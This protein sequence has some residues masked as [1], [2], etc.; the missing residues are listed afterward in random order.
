MIILERP[1]DAWMFRVGRDL[2]IL[3]EKTI[4]G[5]SCAHIT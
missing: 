3:N 4:M 2:V 5:G 1:L